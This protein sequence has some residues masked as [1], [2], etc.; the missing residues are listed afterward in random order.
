V[1][2]FFVKA[3]VPIAVLALLPMFSSARPK[4]SS[5]VGKP[6]PA[7][8]LTALKSMG[9]KDAP[10][11]IEVFSDYQCPQCRIFYL[12]TARQLMQ[13]YIPA[14][15]VYYVHR[16][17]PLSMHSHSREAAR[18]ASAA[19]LAGVF[20]TAEQTLYTKQEEWGS[21]GKI[22]DALSSAISPTDMKKVRTIEATQGPQIDAAIARDMA[23]G[24]S[25]GVNGTPSIYVFHKGQMT[26]LPPGGVNYSLLK[27]YIDY[28][29]Q[30]H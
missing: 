29:L 19:A 6:A 20:E 15:K 2:R 28:L 10:I 27:Q 8:D 5:P 1:N 26:P 25:R 23:L 7:L 22:E 9:S 17:F 3:I 13:T 18:W 24:D 11:T 14:G 16:D 21:S 30:Q 12:E 4:Q